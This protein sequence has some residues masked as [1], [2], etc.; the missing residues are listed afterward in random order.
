MVIK[1]IEYKA[2]DKIDFYYEN[3]FQIISLIEN[4]FWMVSLD[5]LEN[6]SF[7]KKPTEYCVQLKDLGEKNSEEL[8]PLLKKGDKITLIIKH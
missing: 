7:W 5:D 6:A 8:L 3:E 4:G 1:K 2:Y